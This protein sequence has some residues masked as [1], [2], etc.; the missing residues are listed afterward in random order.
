MNIMRKLKE[1]ILPTF[2]M[3][4]LVSV[5]SILGVLIWPNNFLQLGI[6]S[7]IIILCIYLIVVCPI[8]FFSFLILLKFLQLTWSSNAN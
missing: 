8:Q 3:T 1:K 7:N 2:G 6:I 4:I 5:P